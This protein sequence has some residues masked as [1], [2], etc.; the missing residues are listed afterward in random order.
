MIGLLLTLMSIFLLSAMVMVTINYVP[1]NQ[2]SI[3][4]AQNLIQTGLTGLQTGYNNYVAATGSV[5]TTSNWANVLTPQYV[6]LPAA[7]L[8]M[9]W[10]YTSG[11]TYGSTTGNYFCLS[12]NMTQAQYQ[13]AVNDMGDFSS[14][15]YFLN[16]ACGST[17][18]GTTP[19]SWPASAALTF[20]VAVG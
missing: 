10:S 16:T 5:P 4:L 9:S 3:L 12:G 11:A 18:N 15:A 1:A 7:P 17:A 19:T 14:Q 6:F 20:W 8:N 2:G 13:A